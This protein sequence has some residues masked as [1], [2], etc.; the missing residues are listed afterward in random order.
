MTRLPLA[1]FVAR[2]EA[3]HGKPRPAIADPWLL[4]L[5]ENVAYLANDKVRREAFQVLKKRIGTD[6]K[7]I[8]GASK[9]ALLEVT[10]HGILA[11]TFVEKLRRCARLSLEQF[12]GQLEPVLNWPLAK[13][14]KALMKFP[15]VGAPGAEKILLFSKTSPILAL[16]SN[17]LRVL[18]RLG[19]GAEGKQYAATYRLVQAAAAA[20]LEPDCKVLIKAHQL[21]RRHG[22]E[23]CRRTKPAC[24]NCTLAVD[25]PYGQR[26]LKP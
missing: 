8:L 6:P 18:L 5:W 3:A 25:C 13:A 20:E 10:R 26:Q 23:T 2:L 14:K 9:D 7:R 21:L 1:Q 22:Q 19:F 4:I 15:G 24:A 16:E 11:E 17:S 12:D